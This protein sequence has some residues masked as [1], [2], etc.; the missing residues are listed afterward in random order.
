[1]EKKEFIDIN[2]CST[3]EQMMIHIMASLKEDDI[4]EDVAKEGWLPMGE[5]DRYSR[6]GID[7][8]KLPWIDKLISLPDVHPLWQV[9]AQYQKVAVEAAKLLYMLNNEKHLNKYGNCEKEN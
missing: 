8:H 9:E 1:M 7:F 3:F 4:L 2:K 5:I 6:F